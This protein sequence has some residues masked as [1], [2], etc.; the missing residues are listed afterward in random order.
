MLRSCILILPQPL[1]GKD[2][3]TVAMIFKV[4]DDLRQDMVVL[5]MF[6]LFERFWQQNGL[7]LPL[8]TYAVVSTWR[9]GGAIELIP[10]AMTVADIQT[11]YGGVFGSFRQGPIT[12]YLQEHNPDPKDYEAALDTFL[13]STAACCVAT[14]VL[15]I[16]DRHND[17]IMIT[18]DGKLFHID[19]GHFMGHTLTFQGVSREKTRFVFTKSMASTILQLGPDAFQTFTSRCVDGYLTLRDHP[20]EILGLLNMMV[21]TPL[22][23]H[24]TTPFTVYIHFS[25]GICL[26]PPSLCTPT[27]PAC[28]PAHYAWWQFAQFM[29]RSPLTFQS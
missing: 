25:F 10:N 9:D 16:G 5:Q 19:F 13:R 2:D 15:G 8:T 1:Q 20:R 12:K 29:H 22:T 4:G 11:T 26:F 6:L 3:S 21:T 18:R 28:S 24:I 17:N 7:D 14:C 23:V 27:Q